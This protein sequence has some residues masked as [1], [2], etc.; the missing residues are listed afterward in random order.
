VKAGLLLLALAAAGACGPSRPPPAALKPVRAPTLADHLSGFLWPIPIRPEDRVSS[1]FGVRGH[2]HHDGLDLRA[3]SGD[4]IYAARE[5]VVRFS[6]TMRG[7]GLTIIIDHGGGVS[8]LYAHAS[9]L[10]V[11]AGER[12]ERGQVIAEVGTTGNAT[13]PHLHFEIA[14]GGRPLDPIPLL[15]RLTSAPSR[16]R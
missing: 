5:G 8:S 14:W 13:G 16:A 3:R 11:R 10:H 15:P 7:Y 4:P 2:R 9:A 1:P 12:V 6:G